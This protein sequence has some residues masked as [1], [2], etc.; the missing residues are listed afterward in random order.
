MAFRRNMMHAI[1][2]QILLSPT[3]KI[4]QYCRFSGLGAGLAWGTLQESTRMLVY[5]SP[6]SQDNQS[7]LSEKNGERLALALCRMHGA[8]LKIGQM[9]RIQDESLQII[10]TALEIA[11]QSADVMP[12]R[13]LNQVLNAEL[14]LDWTS[15][16]IRYDYEPMA[17]ACIGQVHR[18]VTKDGMHTAMK[19]QYP[20]VSDSIESDIENVKLL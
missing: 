7:V 13:Q 12:K 14:G 15:K 17:P 1:V 11:R 2:M 9:L 4:E 19:I 3:P 8:A 6:S 5:G 16:L 10:R 20:G 18:A